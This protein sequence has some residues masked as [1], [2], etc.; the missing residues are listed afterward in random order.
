VRPYEIRPGIVPL[1][2]LGLG[3]ILDGAFALIRRYPRVTLG[4]SALV[5]TLSAGITLVVN[6]GFSDF[7][8]V[9]PDDTNVGTAVQNNDGFQLHGATLLAVVVTAVLGFVLTGLLTTVVGEAVL[10]R[11][12][13]MAEAWARVRPRFFGLVGVSLLAGILPF[14]GLIALIVG[15]VYLWGALALAVP[16][17]VLEGLGPIQALRRSRRLVRGSWWRVFGIRL[18]AYL[19]VGLISSIITIPFAIAG[20]AS[21][22]VFGGEAPTGTPVLFFVL[23]ALGAL[24]AQTITA[25]VTAAILALLY[26]DRRI[27]AEALDVTLIATVTGAATG[28]SASQG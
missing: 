7:P 1:R 27:R 25:P 6:L 5:A 2:P 8:D 4:L 18:L 13:T 16:A 23:I 21:T 14:V 15:G 26:V 22:G 24:V 28:V 19:I 10:G 11:P 3:E 20:F 9:N 17:Y 12:I